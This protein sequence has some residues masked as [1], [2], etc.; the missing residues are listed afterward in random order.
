MKENIMN[1]VTV[2]KAAFGKLLLNEARLAIRTPTGLAAGLGL[3]I[4]LL[5]IFGSIPKLTDSTKALGGVSYFAASFPILIGIS[6]LTLSFINLPSRLASY[7]EQG[8]LRRLSTTPIPPS[9]LLTAQVVI[10]LCIAFIGIVI[11]TVV[12][13]R[14]FNLQ[15]PQDIWYFILFIVVT[16]T[17]FFSIGLCIASFAKNGNV[18]NVI[19]G[20]LFYPMLLFSG[21]WIPR[22]IMPTI[23]KTMS[24]WSPMGASVGGIQ[25]AM[26]G[27]PFSFQYL[28]TL[29]IYT[30][31]FGFIAVKFFKWE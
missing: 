3:P 7:R 11:L 15:P 26:Q 8:I 13:I 25:N 21:I 16:I 17:A 30:V 2:P 14:K 6:I 27:N 28:L 10:N 1:K 19:G 12:G 22:A 5:V 4:L 31:I 20:T 29:A 9:W 18:A 23:L 24:D